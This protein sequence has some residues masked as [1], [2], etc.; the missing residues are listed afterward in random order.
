MNQQLPFHLRGLALNRALT[1]I[2]KFILMG[3]WLQRPQ[4]LMILAKLG[5]ARLCTQTPSSHKKS[6]PGEGE[7]WDLC[8]INLQLTAAPGHSTCSEISHCRPHE[9]YK[10]FNPGWMS[11]QNEMS[12]RNLLPCSIWS[13]AVPIHQP[14]SASITYKWHF[15]NSADEHPGQT[16]GVTDNIC[17]CA[18]ILYVN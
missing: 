16:A 12:A 10:V 14:Y 17:H 18:L 1:R 7:S 4:G 6:W 5:A 9:N 8:H 11:I 3:R 2:I 15:P 13:L